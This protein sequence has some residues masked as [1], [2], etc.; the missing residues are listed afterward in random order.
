MTGAIA[1]F[2]PMALKAKHIIANPGD[3]LTILIPLMVFYL[4][5]FVF[6]S[7]FGTVLAFWAYVTLIGRIGA[8]RASYT[9]L[10]F[11]L[12]A[13]LI[14]TVVEGYQWTLVAFAGLCLVLAGNWLVMRRGSG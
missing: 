5:T 9:T 12:V 2:Y 1:G 13:L 10:L 7:I 11:P 14:S 3:L 4:V 8:D 6:L